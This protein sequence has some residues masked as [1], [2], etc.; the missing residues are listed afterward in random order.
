MPEAPLTEIYP[1]FTSFAALHAA[2][3]RTQKGT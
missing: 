1:R 3:L 2:S